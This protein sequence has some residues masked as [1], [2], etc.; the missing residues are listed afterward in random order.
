MKPKKSLVLV[1]TIVL[2]LFAFAGLARAAEPVN[3]ILVNYA[4]ILKAN[5]MPAGDKAQA[6]KVAD[7]ETATL[8]LTKFASGGEVKAHFHKT[9]SETLY[10]IEGSGQMAVDGKVLEFQPGS[11]I[12]IPPTKVHSVKI[13]GNTDLIAL[14]VFAPQWK[15]PDRVFVP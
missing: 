1:G 6:I 3:Q 5:P 4:D 14:Q 9:H 8:F 2:L 10:I 12:H 13:T 15:D 11:I 7:D